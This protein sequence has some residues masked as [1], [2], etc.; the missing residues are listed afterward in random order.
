MGVRCR[1]LVRGEWTPVVGWIVKDSGPALEV[2]CG[3][4]K[5]GFRV[6]PTS[7]MSFLCPGS[8]RTSGLMG[9]HCCLV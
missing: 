9:V 2:V 4:R 8:G 6:A 7:V 3:L 1:G 5:G